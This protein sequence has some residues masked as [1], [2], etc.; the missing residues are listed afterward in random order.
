LVLGIV[1]LAEVTADKKETADLRATIEN[2]L[3]AYESGDIDTA[4]QTYHP[5][6]L[7]FIQ[8]GGLPISLQQQTYENMGEIKPMLEAGAKLCLNLKHLDV[9][10]YGTAGIAIGYFNVTA[11]LPNGAVQGDP[12]HRYS[13]TWV[14]MDGKWKIV[15]TH[16][17]P[18][19]VE[20][21]AK[22][23]DLKDF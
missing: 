10:V 8:G 9:K 22:L 23:E 21:P 16:L 19:T 1:V 11:T 6:A 13:S 12:I 17:S 18:L 14:K 4:A 20:L 15:H 5:D 2:L 3:A 7:G